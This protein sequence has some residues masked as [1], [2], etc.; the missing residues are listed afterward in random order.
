MKLPN[1]PL[2]G[3]LLSLLVLLFAVAAL[4]LV[5]L[6]P[7]SQNAAVMGTAIGAFTVAIVG[8]VTVRIVGRK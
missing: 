8:V 1:D 2:L 3:P 7:F 5:V 4:Y 6:L